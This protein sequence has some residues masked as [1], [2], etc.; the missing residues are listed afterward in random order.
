[1][2]SENE[3]RDLVRR[4]VGEMAATGGES[5]AVVSGSESIAIGADHGGYLL[6]EKLVAHLRDQGYEVVDCGT[7]GPDSVDY[8]DF[9][10][11]VARHRLNRGER[12]KFCPLLAC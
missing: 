4:V 6:K 11:A 7:D 2:T 3:I 8:P 1:M 12:I 10:H 9:A 5:E